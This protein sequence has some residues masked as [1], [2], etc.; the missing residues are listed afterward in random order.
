VRLLLFC[1]IGNVWLLDHLAGTDAV[2]LC[3]LCVLGRKQREGLG[4]FY[5]KHGQGDGLLL[6]VGIISIYF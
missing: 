3:I 2:F 6:L 5:C 1:V 4:C